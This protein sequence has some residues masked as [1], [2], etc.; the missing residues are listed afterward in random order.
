M[1][2]DFRSVPDGQ[3]TQT[4][5]SLIRD[6]KYTEVSIENILLA[7]K[8]W[9]LTLF[10][11]FAGYRD[12]HEWAAIFAKKPRSSLP[13][14]LLLFLHARLCKRI[15]NVR[16][17]DQILPRRDPVQ[18]LP[19]LVPPQGWYVLGG[20]KGGA[21]DWSP[22]LCWE[23]LAALS[24]HLVRIRRDGSRKVFDRKYA[25]RFGRIYRLTRLHLVQRGEIWW[26]KTKVPRSNQYYRL[27]MWHSLQY[28][29]LLLQA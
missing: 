13:A 6:Q 14:C 11:T 21:I 29:S 4:I 27:S 5:Y 19:C 8:M 1:Q 2:A 17:V 18:A 10:M 16:S 7:K 15:R 3:Y 25:A 26:C 20:I 12:P 23:N 22:W 9:F 28:C 24:T